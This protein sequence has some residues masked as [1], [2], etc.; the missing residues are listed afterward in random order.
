VIG[1]LIALV[2][3]GTGAGVITYQGARAAQAR[4]AAAR[5]EFFGPGR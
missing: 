1:G 5:A 3:A 4:V 2:L